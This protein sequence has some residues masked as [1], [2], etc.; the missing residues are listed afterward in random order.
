LQLRLEYRP[1]LF[2]R[3][4]A[5]A[6]VARFVRLIEAAVGEPDRSIGR[7]DVLAPSERLQVL[8]GWNNNAR[9]IPSATVPEL[10]AAVA[11]RMPDAV[12]V[13]CE[14]V[15]LTY[16]ELD[17][18]SGRLANHLRGL[19]VAPESV[20]GLCVERSLDMVVGLIGI[21]RAGGAYLPLDPD[22]PRDRLA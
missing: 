1:D 9:L 13:A 4:E 18:R 21:L 19:G 22:Y 14:E 7:L 16:G 6:I 5:E 8:H 10:F 17:A 3:A 11:A 20:V 2:G 12:A 15:S